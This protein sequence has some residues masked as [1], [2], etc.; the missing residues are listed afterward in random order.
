M[1]K[2]ENL[3]KK[4]DENILFEKFNLTID[5]GEFVV[6]AGSSGSGKTTLLNMIGGLE[7][8]D[9]GKILVNNIDV[10]SSKNKLKLFRTE[11]GFLFQNFAL[12]ESKTVEQ[13]LNLVKKDFRSTVS[14]DTALETVGLLDKKNNKVFTLSGGEQQR[15]ALARLMIKKCNVILADEPTGS[16]DSKNET[17][18][19]DLLNHLREEG[20]TIIVVTHSDNIINYGYKVITL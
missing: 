8:I 3:H 19:L 11:L 9:S 16:L 7:N 1:I 5:K 20:K 13:N 17:K 15:I 4:Y 6:I 10:S 2:I 12:V 14:M 18:V